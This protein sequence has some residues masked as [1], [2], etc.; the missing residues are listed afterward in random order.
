MELN[1]S[2]A[3]KASVAKDATCFVPLFDPDLDALGLDQAGLS[4]IRKNNLN[5]A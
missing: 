5:H 4:L 2:H 3:R 1:L